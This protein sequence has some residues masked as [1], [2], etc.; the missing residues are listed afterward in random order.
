MKYMMV[1]WLHDFEDEPVLLYSEM[2]EER[3][4]LRKIEIYEN[5]KVGYADERIEVGDARLSKVPLP[6]LKEIALDEE[7]IPSEIKMEEFEKMWKE[8][9]KSSII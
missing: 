9:A 7:F 6:E 4:E 8:K 2:D 3:N 1:K 5:G